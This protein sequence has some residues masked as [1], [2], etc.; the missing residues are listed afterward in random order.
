MTQ[1]HFT[2]CRFEH[3]STEN[4]QAHQLCFLRCKFAAV[5]LS[6]SL[7]NSCTF[8]ECEIDTITLTECGLLS[9]SFQQTTIQSLNAGKCLA[10]RCM[11]SGGK[12][13]ESVWKEVSLS[14]WSANDCEISNW[15]TE[16]GLVQDSNWFG[17]TINQFRCTGV[18]I[19]RLVSD[20][21]KLTDCQFTGNECDIL[22]WQNCQL[23]RTDLRKLNLA[24]AGF[25]K[26]RLE[27]CR[28]DDSNLH[29]AQFNGGSLHDCTLDDTK[30]TRTDM[31]FCQ[32]KQTPLHNAAVQKVRLHGA[33]TGLTD[34]GQ[35]ADEP[36]LTSIDLWYA[37]HQPGLKDDTGSPRLTPGASRYV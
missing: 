6:K 1:L 32:L 24:S 33:E 20:N 28:L 17:C 11:I 7:F 25:A 10:E 14:Y 34:R 27:Q 4:I 21:S 13:S 29:Y 35:K 30:L 5:S 31:R 3:L 23:T 19:V 18:Q 8:I 16:G 26:S 37:R 36:L 12:V 9:V 15:H 2:D 22:V